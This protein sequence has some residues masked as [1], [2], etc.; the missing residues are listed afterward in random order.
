MPL[1][2][3]VQGQD[4]MVV[5]EIVYLGCLIHSSTGSIC[6][7][8]R[9]SAITR[10][11][12]QSLEN[13]IWRSRLA[14]STKLKLYNTCI[15]PLGARKKQSYIFSMLPSPDLRQFLSE[16]LFLGKLLP[17]PKLYS[18]FELASFN[19]YKNKYRGPT[20]LGCSPSR[21]LDNFGH[22]SCF[23]V[24]YSPSPT[25]IPNLKLLASTVAEINRGSPLFWILPQPGPLPILVV[26]VVSRQ[27]TPH[28]PSPSC[29]PNL[30]LLA[31]MV[32]EI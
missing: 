8:S 21:T 25:C 26:K 6:D 17:K 22:K 5:K 31:S 12:L 10:A 4:V 1:T 7:I 32:A 16:K 24:R 15:L 29:I 28:S 14:I 13:Q 27:A 30:K 20:F 11:A 19:D 2:I 3:K 18:K 23:L 9:Q